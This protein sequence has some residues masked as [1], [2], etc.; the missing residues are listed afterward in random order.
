[1]SDVIMVAV[2]I[3][4]CAVEVVGYAAGLAQR[5]GGEVEV[6]LMHVTDVP[7]LVPPLDEVL[8]G[9]HLDGA[10]HALDEEATAKLEEL[11]DVFVNVG[12]SV[13]VEVRHGTPVDAILGCA[14]AHHPYLIVV[15]THGRKG[16][17]R[18]L[19]GSVAE[20]VVRRAPVPVLTVRTH[21]DA[22][23]GLTAVQQQVMAETLG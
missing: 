20:Q 5:M 4:G 7:L 12:V 1:M 9:G 17:R 14:K 23:P 21:S 8:V 11:A 16:L 2:D 10:L 18:A 15:G 3:A 13:R 22:H 6:V 19:M